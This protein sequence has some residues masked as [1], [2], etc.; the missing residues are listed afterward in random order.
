MVSCG[1]GVV[2]TGIVNVGFRLIGFMNPRF[3]GLDGRKKFALA[4]KKKKLSKPS[5][6]RRPKK[7]LIGMITSSGSRDANAVV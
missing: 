7:Y 1:A 2:G 3:P 4:C 6:E 5:D